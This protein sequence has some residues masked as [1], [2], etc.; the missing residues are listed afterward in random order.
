MDI[1]EFIILCSFSYPNIVQVFGCTRI[2]ENKEDSPY[3]LPINVF[4]LCL[5]HIQLLFFSEKYVADHMT[6]NLDF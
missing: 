5:R 1:S 6:E 3:T 4:L 2:Q